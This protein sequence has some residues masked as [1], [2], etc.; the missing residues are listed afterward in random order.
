MR[1]AYG[2]KPEM[3]SCKENSREMV[4]GRKVDLELKVF[5][6]PA[7]AL[8]HHDKSCRR[9]LASQCSNGPGKC[10]NIFLQLPIKKIIRIVIFDDLIALNGF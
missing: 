2:R 3:T 7:V 8:L 1:E 6:K 10:R 4:P 9:F 5:D